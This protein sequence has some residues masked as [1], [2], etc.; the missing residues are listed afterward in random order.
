MAGLAGL[1]ALGGLALFAR[2]RALSA[3][4]TQS[5]PPKA[6][7]GLLTATTGMRNFLIGAALAFSSTQL[8]LAGAVI[9]TVGVFG[10]LAA[11]E[12]WRGLGLR[13]ETVIAAVAGIIIVLLSLTLAIGSTQP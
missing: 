10:S 13:A 1:L 8:M 3:A 12:A 2:A 11:G 4:R 9:M 5:A 7:L 6:G